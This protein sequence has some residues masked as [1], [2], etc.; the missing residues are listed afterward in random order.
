MGKKGDINKIPFIG[1]NN[2]FL[3]TWADLIFHDLAF[4]NGPNTQ[5]FDQC[6]ILVG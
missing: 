3:V 2:S 1:H 6:D 5:S 4:A